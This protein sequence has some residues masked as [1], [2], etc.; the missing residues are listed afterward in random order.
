M[1]L[2]YR[3]K[4]IAAVV[5][6]FAVLL[7]GFFALV[8]PKYNTIQDNEVKLSQKEKEKADIE[9]M[10]SEIP[11]LKKDITNTYSETNKKTEIFVAVDDV[12]NPVAVDEYLQKLADDNKV[13]IDSLQVK[14]AAVEDIP[15]YFYKK[16]DNLAD[17]RKSADING[18]LQEQFNKT[19]AESVSLSGATN[20]KVLKTDYGVQIYGTKKHIW[21]YLK[22]IKEFDK[23]ITVKSVSMTD[24]SF[25]RNTVKD[26]G[27]GDWDG[28]NSEDEQTIQV[29]DKTITNTQSA[30]IVITLYS[31]YEMDEPNVD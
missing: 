18:R 1:K 22:A 3:D 11:G 26:A 12:E 2:N 16:E 30:Q 19:Y 31:V 20:E 14:A 25:G 5:L 29:G 13:R 17:A 27:M 7:L 10:I 4:I 8:R 15:F 21:N 9:K 28:P 23:A 6:A 24:P